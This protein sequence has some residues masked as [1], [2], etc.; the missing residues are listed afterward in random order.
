MNGYLLDTNA[1]IFALTLPERLSASARRAILKGPNLLSVVTY[2][3]V[4]LKCMK[5]LLDVGDPREW[6]RDALEELAAVPLPLRPEHV[7]AVYSLPPHH[8]DP[9]DRVLIAQ[10]TVEELS[11]VTSDKEVS[12]YAGRDL[13]IIR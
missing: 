8:K 7:A 5:G 1:A 6:W 11:F 12:K 4:L 13:K 2:W 9:F 10:A 3:E